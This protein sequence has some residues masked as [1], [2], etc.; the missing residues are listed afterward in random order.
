MTKQGTVGQ[1]GTWGRAWDT[2][3]D[4]AKDYLPVADEGEYCDWQT[5][6]DTGLTCQNNVCVKPGAGPVVEG[7]PTPSQQCKASG[8][9]WDSESE[10]CYHDTDPVG[11][12][13]EESS[14]AQP[15]SS[16]TGTIVAVVAAAV[17]AG[18]A[19]FLLLGRDG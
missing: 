18:V 6:C 13:Y 4:T 2:F 5:F 17:V 11:W 1:D 15:A 14:S 9:E 19:T 8:G 16:S 10:Q 12:N 7:G 3:V